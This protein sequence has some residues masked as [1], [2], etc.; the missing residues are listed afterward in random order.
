MS[1]FTISVHTYN[2][3]TTPQ[4]PTPKPTPKHPNP[5]ISREIVIDIRSNNVGKSDLL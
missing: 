5:Q 4:T 3:P 2:P 1:K